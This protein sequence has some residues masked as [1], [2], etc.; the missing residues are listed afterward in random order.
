MS[1]QTDTLLDL[2][3]IRHEFVSGEAMS[4]ALGISR[5]AVHK[6]INA[7]RR[8]G[9]QITGGTRRGSPLDEEPSRLSRERVADLLQGHAFA[10]EH[11]DEIG[12]TNRRA[13][14]LALAGA[15]Q[16][17]VVIAERQTEGRGRLGREWISPAGRG[18]LLSVILRPRMAMSDVH[19]LTL[20][21]A[22]AAAAA[23]E[24]QTGLAV[25]IKWPNDLFVA[26]RKVAGI[27]LEVA[28]EHDEVD[29]VVLGLGINATTTLEELP[30]ELSETATSLSLAG[31]AP[32]DRE[33]L[34]AAVLLEVEE[35]CAEAVAQGFSATLAA[36]RERDRLANQTV[37]IETREGPVVGVA[38]GIDDRGALLVRLPHGAVRRFH[39]G[40]VTL[41]H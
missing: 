28:G 22:V 9:Y 26:G 12:S 37:S 24:A 16:G 34:L 36:F 32:V 20:V 40:D 31:G 11:H 6:Q 4:T 33:A 35:S 21:T 2:L 5:N 39:S 38:A 7:L 13:K 17:T 27:L 15:P 1:N 41:H 19:L 18:V 10:V 14:E 30:A 3:R 25:Q 23:V 29:W 8:Q